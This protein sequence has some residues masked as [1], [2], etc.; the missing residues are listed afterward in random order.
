MTKANPLGTEKIGTLIL[1]FSIPAIIGM[2]VSATYNIVDRIY[3][4]NAVDL[5]PNGLA[6]ITV[7]FPL[8]LIQLAIGV[9]FGVGGATLFA[10]RLGQKKPHEAE[11]V[12]GNAFV[13][14]VVT[15]LIY[16]AFGQLFLTQI[17]AL[18]GASDTI[19]PYA[20]DYLRVIFLGSVFQ[21]VSIGLN[22]FIRA[23]GSPRIAMMTMFIG[24]GIN[25]I[26]DPI[27]IYGFGWGMAG[28]AWATIL[29]QAVSATWVVMY[30]IGK[31]SHHHLLKVNLR[32]NP[33]LVKQIAAL[34]MPG[35]L[36]QLASSV[37]NTVLNK[38]LLTYG[39]D[40]AISG[41]GVINSVQ[42]FLIMPV[43]GLN[44]GVQPIVSFNFGAHQFKRVRQAILMAISIATAIV[45]TGFLITRFFPSLLVALFN[46]DADLMAFTVPALSTWFLFLPLVGFQILGANFFQAI[47]RYK[48]AMVLT[49]TRQVLILIP[50]VLIL[51][52][53]FGLQGI[54][55]AAPLADGLASVLTLFVFIKAVRE[56]EKIPAPVESGLEREVLGE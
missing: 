2:V 11:Q 15:S 20:S 24:A 9:L 51:P 29:A 48:T 13:L 26:L 5:G 28:A 31:R 43:I 34:G 14:L 18:F 6:G 30:F 10:I 55:Y 50:A 1:R 46:R 21:I 40:L 49:L 12:L 19:L 27:F 38:S 32:L 8:M 17:L 7:S 22:H 23:D 36:L 45:G 56:L 39:G 35:F 47:G 3:I 25:I 54:L 52:R 42:T 37:L 41:M 16:M 33:V 53:V 44:Q 4:G